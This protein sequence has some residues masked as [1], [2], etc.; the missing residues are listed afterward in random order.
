MN[1]YLT[2]SVLSY[3]TTLMWIRMLKGDNVYLKVFYT[4]I[5]LCASVAYIVNLFGGRF[6]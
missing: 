6:L 5:L 2:V 3:T 4:C 1:Y